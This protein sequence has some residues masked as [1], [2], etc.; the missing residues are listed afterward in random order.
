MKK[1]NIY[2]CLIVEEQL[3]LW[4]R[5][6]TETLREMEYQV[7]IPPANIGLREYWIIKD[8][9]YWNKKYQEKLTRKILDDVRSRHQ[10][11]GVDLFFCYL[12]PFQFQPN[13][14]Q[15][16]TQLGIPS[17]Y[18]FCDNFANPEVASK[19]A[20]HCTL[21]W[22]PEINAIQ[23]FEISKSNY[24]YL[25]MAANPKY[26]YPLK[27][28]EAYDLSFFGTKNPYRRNI[29]GSILAQGINLRLFGD[30]WYSSE[31]NYHQL[32]IEE[33]QLIKQLPKFGTQDKILRFL[34]YKQSALISFMKYGLKPRKKSGEYLNLGI[35]YDNL[36]QD[37]AYEYPL[38]FVK[39]NE[40]Y[41]L[42]SITIGIND[43][44]N[45]YLQNSNVIYTKLRDFESTMAGACYLTQKTPDNTNFFE[46]GKEIMTYQSVEELIDKIKFLQKHDEIRNQLR[47][48]AHQR[49]LL[50]HTW[51]HRFKK[52]FAKLGLI[53]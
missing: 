9:G 3:N 50:E 5:Q 8:M 40:I 20:P 28:Q 15:E 11:Y 7:F 49:A 53:N 22:V 34:K 19:Y 30:G 32:E 44:F 45:P 18:F 25:P 24:I 14:F 26:N 41:S 47:N 38:D 42:S 6:L 10:H 39:A 16:L 43:Q 29:L 46:E 17:L 36:F 1:L 12:Y 35:E 48:N 27:I 21:N 37:V 23:Q 33:K 51:T 31:R 2:A 52:A 13:L 4:H